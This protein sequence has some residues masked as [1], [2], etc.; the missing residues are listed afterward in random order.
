[1][2]VITFENIQKL[3]EL[4][5]C[6][7]DVIKALTFKKSVPLAAHWLY[8]NQAQSV[9]PRE[10]SQQNAASSSSFQSMQ[11]ESTSTLDLSRRFNT[12]DGAVQVNRPRGTESNDLS[13]L[14]N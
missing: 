9:V 8:A 14:G 2:D 13:V 3:M 4:G 10:N 5:F 11:T 7:Q 12:N 1:M 6:K